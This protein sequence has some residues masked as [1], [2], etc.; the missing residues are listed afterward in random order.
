MSS[1]AKKA[2]NEYMRAW[3]KDHPDRVRKYAVR[4]WQR[5]AER[6]REQDQKSSDVYSKIPDKV[7]MR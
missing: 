5:V 2:R 6:A 4:H 7:E 1:E 3:R